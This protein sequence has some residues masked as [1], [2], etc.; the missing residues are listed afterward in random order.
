MCILAAVIQSPRP[1]WI[2]TPQN[3]QR[4][5]GL[6][7]PPAMATVGRGDGQRCYSSLNPLHLNLHVDS[8]YIFVL[9]KHF[10]SLSTENPHMLL[11]LAPSPLK[12]PGHFI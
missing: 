2:K 3:D 8:G 9:L 12:H 7:S 5:G 6:E 1:F 4:R 11:F 10:L